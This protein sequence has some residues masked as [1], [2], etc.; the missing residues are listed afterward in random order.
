MRKKISLIVL[1][2]LLAGLISV[3]VMDIQITREIKSQIEILPYDSPIW[4]TWNALVTARVID[5]IFSFTIFALILVLILKIGPQKEETKH[6]TQEDAQ[7]IAAELED[8]YIQS[9]IYVMK[10]NDEAEDILIESLDVPVLK[11]AEYGNNCVEI[12]WSPVKYANGYSVW[13]KTENQRWGRIAR[14]RTDECTYKDYQLDDETRYCYTVKAFAYVD[15]KQIVSKK[16][17]FGVD[18]Y[19][20]K[21]NI[22]GVPRISKE[23]DEQGKE[24]LTWTPIPQI[25]VYRIL[26]KERDGEWMLLTRVA[27]SSPRVFRDET[28]LPGESYYY[29]VSAHRVFD[30]NIVSGDFDEEAIMLKA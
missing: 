3:I 25:K 19:V 18:A 27:P 12:N 16:D 29:T 1:V 17:S 5:L 26:R 23:L 2:L 28:A 22:P 20:T 9:G 4:E 7:K 10:D 30:G 11:S 6:I 21:G 15:G 8:K 24:C 13:R 14:L